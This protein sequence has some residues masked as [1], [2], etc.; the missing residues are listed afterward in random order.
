M[1]SIRKN[2]LKI[3]KSR[4]ILGLVLGPLILLTPLER[5]SEE[6]SQQFLAVVNKPI[7]QSQLYET[8]VQIMHP[9]INQSFTPRGSSKGSEL[10]THNQLAQEH[11]LRI[12]V[13]EDNNINQKLI[14][15]ILK[16][17]GY[18]A[19]VVPNG[20]EVL[21]TLKRQTYDLI[22]M[23]VQMPEMD[24]LEATRLIVEQFSPRPRIVAMTANAMR[25]DAEICLEAG[26][27]DYLGK[28][29]RIPE[30]IRVLRESPSLELGDSIDWEALTFMRESICGGDEDLVQK[31]VDCFLEE[32]EKLLQSLEMAIVAQDSKM[33]HYYAHS[34]KSS[35]AAF[36][37]KQLTQ[38][39][40]ELETESRSNNP[41][42]APETTIALRTAF[43]EITAYL[44]REILDHP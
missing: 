17:I 26:M 43:T 36:G 24:G 38:L 13:A 39:C 25:G 31:M 5:L 9:E 16:Q 14:I 32:G 30:L 44:R 22:L 29:I 1:V 12:L 27:D 34:L 33:L 15:E 11:P 3:G 18:Q 37:A 20:L 35:A 28:P 10:T 4:R 2:W 41:E 8:L 40:Q 42:V 19:D 6:I 23:D 21:A 7:K